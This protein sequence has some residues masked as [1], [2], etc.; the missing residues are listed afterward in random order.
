MSLKYKEIEEH[1]LWDFK[2]NESFFQWIRE[3]NL[4]QG[5]EW[6]T[7]DV[8]IE[9]SSKDEMIAHEWILKP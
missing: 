7:D 1:Y 4:I 3:N 9:Q 6:T 5:R 8:G 2:N